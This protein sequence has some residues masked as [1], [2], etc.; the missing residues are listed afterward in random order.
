MEF[1]TKGREVKPLI[2]K[3][4]IVFAFSFTGFLLSQFGSWRIR[5]ALKEES[6]DKNVILHS[7]IIIIVPMVAFSIGNRAPSFQDII[8]RNLS[9]FKDIIS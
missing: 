1:L 5:P 9:Y 7:F 6:H 4:S 3:L 8:L 2:L